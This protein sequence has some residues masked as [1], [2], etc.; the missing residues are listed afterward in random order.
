MLQIDLLPAI[1]HFNCNAL[2]IG[3]WRRIGQNRLDLMVFYSPAKATI[4]YYIHAE[5][6]GF[7]IEYPF[8]SIKSITLNT[9][10]SPDAIAGTVQSGGLVVELS[11]PPTFS[12]DCGSGVGFFHC[13]DFTED[14]Q[15]S[16]MLMHHIGGDSAVLGAQLAKLA[17]LDTFRNRHI[18]FGVN[19]LSIPGPLT[20]PLATRPSSQTNHILHPHLARRFVTQPTVMGPPPG[21]GHKRQRSRSVPAA[22]DFSQFRQQPIPS[23]L[24]QQDLST[25]APLACTPHNPLFAPTPQHATMSMAQPFTDFDIAPLSAP[26]EHP[27]EID[28]SPRYSFDIPLGAMSSTTTANS[29]S[30]YESTFLSSAPPSEAFTSASN[31]TPYSSSFLSPMPDPSSALQA[32]ISPLSVQIHGEPFIANQSPPLGS[33]I[34]RSASDDL[35][36][37]ANIPDSDGLFMD[38]SFAY[39]D[40]YDKQQFSLPFR[41][42]MTLSQQPPLVDDFEYASMMHM[43]DMNNDQ[44]FNETS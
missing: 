22:I 4:T 14:K 28:T 9:P 27:L 25:A 17:S 16:K 40:F 43:Y 23:F 13:P 29:P 42:S 1:V 5:Q 19:N 35:Y 37:M 33:N 3:T 6:S 30:E 7:K 18:G 15:A 39:N 12:M 2:N 24:F 38:E 20:S 31:Q 11:R 21:R 10:E 34:G 41:N 44:S 32:P 36:S 8:S 26:L